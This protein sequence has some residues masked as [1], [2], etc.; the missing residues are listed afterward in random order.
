[1]RKEISFETKEDYQFKYRKFKHLYHETQKKKN[2][3]LLFEYAV[4]CIYAVI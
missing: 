2:Q 4:E 1:M 3:L